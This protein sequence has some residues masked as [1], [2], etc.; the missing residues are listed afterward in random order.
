MKYIRNKKTITI[1]IVTPT[2]VNSG[3]GFGSVD[4][5]NGDNNASKDNPLALTNLYGVTILILNISS[6]MSP[7]PLLPV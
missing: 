3:I 7:K 4:E 6:L 1:I 2:V 5:V